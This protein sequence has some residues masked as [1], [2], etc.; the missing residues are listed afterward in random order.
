LGV[1]L[2]GQLLFV[3]TVT[4]LVVL[5]LLALSVVDPEALD[6]FRPSRS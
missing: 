2:A 1:Y 3:A 6:L 5:F 4:L